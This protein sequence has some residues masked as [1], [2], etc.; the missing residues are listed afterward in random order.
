MSRHICAED[1]SLKNTPV[2]RTFLEKWSSTTPTCQDSGQTLGSANGNHGTAKPCAVGTTVRST[3]HKELGA[4]AVTVRCG[5]SA[6][7]ASAPS[8]AS[9]VRALRCFGGGRP[10]KRFFSSLPTC[11]ALT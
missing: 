5:S 3:C 6:A 8:D 4:L 11:E 1:G 7:T 9:P 10:N 2:A